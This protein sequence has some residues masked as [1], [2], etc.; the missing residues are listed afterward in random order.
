MIASRS[1]RRLLFVAVAA[2]C[3]PGC[4]PGRTAP[5]DANEDRVPD[6]PPIDATKPTKNSIAELC[7]RLKIKPEPGMFTISEGQIREVRLNNADIKDISPLE[8][9]P[10]THLNLLGTQ[11]EDISVVKTLNL[12]T[13]WLN[14]TRVKDLS[15]LKGKS[16]ESLDITGTPVTDLSPLK[17]MTSLRRLKLSHSKVT[18]LTP[19]NGLK[20][21]RIIFNPAVVT[22]GLDA[23]RN[24]ASLKHMHTRFQTDPRRYFSPA[25]FWDEYDKRTLPPE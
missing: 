25:K 13:L 5:S 1:L 23:V 22:R 7:E 21:Q 20:L 16:L 14:G 6:V 4:G 8:G 18:D 11:V 15:P 9:L 3:L 19:L 24:M 12:N 2:L 17:G 10:L